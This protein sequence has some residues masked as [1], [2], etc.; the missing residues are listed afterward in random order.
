[1]MLTLCKMETLAKQIRNLH[2]LAK[3]YHAMCFF[4]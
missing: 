1:M 4:Y 3:K 2:L